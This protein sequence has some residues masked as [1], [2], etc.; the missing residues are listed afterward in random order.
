MGKAKETPPEVTGT[1]VEQMTNEGMKAM[2]KKLKDLR[3]KR[4]HFRSKKYG[5]SW[6]QVE[7]SHELITDYDHEI[8]MILRRR[9]QWIAILACAAAALSAATALVAVLSR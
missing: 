6:N 9:Y 8:E 4:E 5:A 1:P 7:V 2:P 3:K